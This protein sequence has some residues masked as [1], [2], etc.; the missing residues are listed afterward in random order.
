MAA[1]WQLGRR[2]QVT[3]FEKQAEIGMAAHGLELGGARVDMPLRVLYRGYYPTLTA[4]YADAGIATTTADYSASFSDVA[5]HSYFRYRNWRPFGRLSLPLLQGGQPIGQR[6]RQIVFDLMRLYRR[7]G[8]DSRRLRASGMTLQQY[9]QEQRYSSSFV[10]DFL[11]PVFAAIGTCSTQSVRNYPARIIIDYLRQG[12]LLQGVSRTVHGADE[13]V[14]RLSSRCCSVRT[15]ASI[16]SI[17]AAGRQWQLR[18]E[19][20][21]SQEFDHV[22]IATQGNQAARLVEAVDAPAAASLR[23]FRYEASEVIVHTDPALMPSRRKNWS[24][25]N[26]FV[27]PQASRPMASIWLNAVLPVRAGT[28]DAFQTWNPLRQ[29]RADSI[30]AQAGFERPVVDDSSET[31][32]A[33]LGRLHAEPDRRLWFCGSYAESGV[34]LLESAARSAREVCRRIDPEL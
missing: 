8:R 26:L 1:S 30:L 11:L 12:V 19:C 28:A 4:L 29:P 32:L 6:S 33:R 3:L 9:V 2:H 23:Q 22:I 7:A 14:R 31:G 13:V 17:R 27:D 34:P 20:G 5:G 24:P 15:S 25:V 21:A 16:Q 18:T 10:E